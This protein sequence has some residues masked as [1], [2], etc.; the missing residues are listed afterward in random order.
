MLGGRQRLRAR[1]RLAAGMGAAREKLATWARAWTPASVRPEPW[2]RTRSPVVRWM[3]S[4]S[5]P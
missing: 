4:E 2:G 5:R 1:C 3:A